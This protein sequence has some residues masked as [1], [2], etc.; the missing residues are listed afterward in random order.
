V[1]VVVAGGWRLWLWFWLLW[2]VVMVMLF[3]LCVVC[4]LMSVVIVVPCC[5][6]QTVRA[7]R[8][9]GYGTPLV[10]PLRIKNDKQIE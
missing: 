9:V 8:A 10:F 6:K 2:L 3:V 4:L 5:W 7:P 1:V